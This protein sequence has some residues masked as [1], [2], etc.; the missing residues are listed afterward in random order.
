MSGS[1]ER[2]GGRRAG[3]TRAAPNRASAGRLWQ[4]AFDLG[5]TAG[6]HIVQAHAFALGTASP[7][8]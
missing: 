3:P 7:T 8:L 1:V 5:R 4:D 2:V 6:D